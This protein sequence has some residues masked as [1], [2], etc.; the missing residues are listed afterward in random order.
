MCDERPITV[1]LP[2]GLFSSVTVNVPAPTP[3]PPAPEAQATSPAKEPEA[4]E[5][6]GPTLGTAGLDDDLYWEDESA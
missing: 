2:L 1:S 5:T 6:P 4:P 3:P